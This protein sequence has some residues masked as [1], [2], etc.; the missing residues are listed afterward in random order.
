MTYEWNV[1][2]VHRDGTTSIITVQGSS[3]AEDAIYWAQAS[4]DQ[5]NIP[6]VSVTAQPK[7]A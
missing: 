2:C 6:A 4:L 5:H 3:T 1:Q 7:G